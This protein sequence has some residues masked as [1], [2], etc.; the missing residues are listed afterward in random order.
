[1]ECSPVKEQAQSLIA[2]GGCT[3][4]LLK[5][6][7]LNGETLQ[8]LILVGGPTYSS[9]LRTMLKEQVT[10]KINYSI[11]PMTAVATG[12]ALFAATKDIPKPIAILE[13]N[14]LCLGSRLAHHVS[15]S[16]LCEAWGL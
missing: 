9:V 3:Y 13:I 15:F 2:K 4:G 10:S 11:D 16:S 7:N 12:A 1:M 8:T 5:K 6:N 14:L